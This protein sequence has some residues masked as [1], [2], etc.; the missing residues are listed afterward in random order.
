MR[1]DWRNSTLAERM[2]FV[3]EL[4]RPV[5]AATNV[6]GVSELVRRIKETTGYEVKKGMIS[7]LTKKDARD[8]GKPSTLR[9]IAESAPVSYVWL[10]L[11]EGQPDDP[12]AWGSHYVRNLEVA[13][14]FGG[15]VEQFGRD[16]VAD[17]RK[18]A[19]QHPDRTPEEWLEA[20]EAPRTGLPRSRPRPIHAR[21]N[22]P[23]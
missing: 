15:G 17:L 13:I 14:A 22:R 12:N 10:S 9:R 16:W 3:I 7:K 4:V 11:G 19:D 23:A 6:K 21:K 20:L 18:T 1:K 8:E 5:D 2:Q